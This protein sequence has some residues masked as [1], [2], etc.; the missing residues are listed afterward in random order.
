MT[1]CFRPWCGVDGKKCVDCERLPA[2]PFAPAVSDDTG[3]VEF[4][5]AVPMSLMVLL[6][7]FCVGITESRPPNQNIGRAGNPYIDRWF[8]ARKATVPTFSFAPEYADELAQMPSEVENIY[9]HGYHRGDADEP[10]DHPWPNASLVVRGWY[11]ENIYALD[12]R[13]LGSVTRRAGDIVLRSATSVHAILETSPDCLSLFATLPKQ[14]DWGFHT[15]G[16]F[17][18][19]RD[20]SG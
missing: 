13:L 4:T 15:A 5:Q 2:L 1:T 12:G 10:H 20:F 8:I 3:M 11:V 17:V 19:W 7:G 9:L 6:A 16:G 14:R 18:P